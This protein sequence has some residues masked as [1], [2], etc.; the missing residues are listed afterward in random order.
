MEF[1][2]KHA[3]ITGASSGIGLAVAHMLVAAGARVTN[4]DVAPPP[5]AIDGMTYLHC[6]VSHFGDVRMALAQAGGHIDLLMSN[7]GIMRRGTL[8]QSTEADF[9][10]LFGVHVKGAWML[11]QE[12]WPLLTKHGEIVFTAS[13]HALHPPKDPGLYAL[14][15]KTIA[16]FAEQL[17]AHHPEHRVRT[18]FIGPTDTPLARQDVPQDALKKKEAIMWNTVDVAKRIVAFLQSN[19]SDL[20]YDQT[21]NDYIETEKKAAF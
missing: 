13:A 1:H 7:A 15:K 14:S 18:L 2:G 8:L 16:A 19:K 12:A 11:V 5:K 4:L 9:D 17:R 3:V 20:V 10:A 21:Q 6:D